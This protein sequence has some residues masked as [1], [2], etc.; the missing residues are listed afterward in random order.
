MSSKNNKNKKK[1]AP[2]DA[3]EVK[4]DET[5]PSVEEKKDAP[6]SEEGKAP[7]ATR[8]NLPE[9][10]KELENEKAPEPEEPV[11]LTKE[12]ELSNLADQRVDA[13]SGLSRRERPRM[14][15]ISAL[16]NAECNKISA[17]WD[18]K[19]NESKQE[20]ATRSKEKLA[21]D[22]EK[23]DKEAAEKQKRGRV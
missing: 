13:L 11:F 17:K 21:L 22:A 5:I 4:K 23:A 2:V 18:A 14:Q 3:P 19:N 7:T 9:E 16:Y 12:A 15:E 1:D 10:S 8:E 6:D 20:K